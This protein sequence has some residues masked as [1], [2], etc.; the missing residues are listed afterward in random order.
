MFNSAATLDRNADRWPDREAVTQGAR[1]LTNAGLLGRVQALAASLRDLD[2]GR[3][4]VVAILLN[5]CP[6]FLEA[7]LAV[8]R[9]GA[10]WLPL[11]WRLAP[12]E[13]E[14]ILGHAGASVLVS[15]PEFAAGVDGVAP[16]LG[17]LRHRVAVGGPQ[18]GWLAYEPLL[19]GG[20]GQAVE[21]AD[22]AEDDVQ[23]L[24]YTSGTTARPKGVMLT[25]G[26][27]L[28][29]NVGQLVEF[30][31]TDADR[32]LVAGPLY[33]VGGMD[34][35]ASTVLYAG[36]SVALLRR[37]DPVQTMEALAPESITNLWLA[38]AMVNA[39]LQLDD[40][41][42]YDTST[43]RLI[44]NGGEKMPVPLIERML[45]AFPN[46]WFSDAYGLTETVSGDTFMD[47]GSAIRKIGSVGKPVV[48]LAVRIVDE[49][50]R[51]VPT[52]G[53]GE[54][55]LRGPKVFRGYWKD[56]AATAAVLRDG[57]FH[58]GD[59]GHLDGDGYLYIDDRKKDLIVSGG[60]N[61]ASPEVERVLYEHP[62]VL[63]AAVVGTPDDRWGEVPKAF[64]ALKEGASA[65]ADELLEHC[66]S[67]LARFKT[68]RAVEFVDALPRNPS[69]KVL[70]R[71]L[72]ERVVR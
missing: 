29:K 13:W 16:R 69:G 32:T 19:E 33:H 37:F 70:K 3:G 59:V 1:R 8:N 67:R 15:E 35:P 62:D 58:T 36:G 44:I 42:A 12:D 26:N 9:L 20:R 50:G 23:R 34:L 21:V 52:G 18:E 46:A 4:S 65:G 72:R 61:I 57:W 71:E 54:V 41:E 49:E 64:V 68:P 17:E 6:E 47:R 27:L 24:M 45:R 38:P 66:R 10:T 53:L 11:N 56:E 31:L 40:L 25:Y 48:H 30:G 22:V 5:N 7:T 63:E 55:V 2:V 28:W 14:Y 60:E 51:D 43:V 39:V